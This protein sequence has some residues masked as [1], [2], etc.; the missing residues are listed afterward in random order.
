MKKLGT[1][2]TL[3]CMAIIL[4]ILSVR[5]PSSEPRQPVKPGYPMPSVNLPSLDGKNVALNA[6]QRK[7]LLIYF[8]ASWCEPCRAETPDLIAFY[9]RHKGDIGVYAVNVTSKDEPDSV[10]SFVRQYNV[11]FPVLLDERGE[12]A[13]QFRIVSIPTT[14]WI[15]AQGIIADR[16]IGQLTPQKLEEKLRSLRR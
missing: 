7:P 10:R 14:Y 6:S 1:Q 13:E 3:I 9:E 8:W 11:R 15:D 12:A 16:F 5:P 2:A 4:L